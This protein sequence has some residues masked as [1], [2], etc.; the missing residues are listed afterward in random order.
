M[1]AGT[2][3]P[4]AGS[5]RIDGEEVR[6]SNLATK[7]RIGY[8]PQDLAIYEELGA[9]DN[10]WF[11]GLLYDL[12][13]ADLDRA[14]DRSLDIVG[15]RGRQKEPVRQFSGG[16]KRRLNIAAALLHDPEFLILD[17]PTVGVDPQSRNQIFETLETL[18]A[19]GKTMLYTTHYMEEVER[20]CKKVAIMDGGKI[21][22]YDDISTLLN[23][24]A[25]DRRVV[26]ETS[27]A[28]ALDSQ[29]DSSM[30]PLQNGRRLSLRLSDI[31]KQLPEVLE[32]VRSLGTIERVSTDTPTLEQVFLQLTGRNVRD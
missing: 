13:G 25:I 26:I 6:V 1:I 28:I 9:R 11:F 3:D 14:I 8:V 2:L 24:L 29:L 31:G 17:E 18:I 21:I 4:D 22:A 30:E 16:M 27:D 5:V 32:T 19:A 10:L 12:G 15:L 20:L 7:R 23:S